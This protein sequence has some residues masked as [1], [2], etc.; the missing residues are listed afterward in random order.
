MPSN[1]FKIAL[2]QSLILHDAGTFSTSDKLNPAGSTGAV[3]FHLNHPANG[4]LEGTFASEFV[5]TIAAR[6]V[7]ASDIIALGGLVAVKHCGG[8][9]IPFIGGRIDD[10][11]TKACQFPDTPNRLPFPME[12]FSQTHVKF[13]RMGLTGEEMAALT[14]GGHSLG[15]VHFG[16]VIRRKRKGD[17][18]N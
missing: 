9:D 16:P 17:K 8:P 14:L 5:T 4:G 18:F 13:Q 3:R 15:G 1:A 6:G 2:S 11:S 10:L 12:N 7:S